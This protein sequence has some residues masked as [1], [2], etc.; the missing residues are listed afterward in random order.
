MAAPEKLV[1][2]GACKK[3]DMKYIE[4]IGTQKLITLALFLLSVLLIVGSFLY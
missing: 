3:K 4:V 1:W 2:H